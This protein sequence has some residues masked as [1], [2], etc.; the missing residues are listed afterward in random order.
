RHFTS[1]PRNLLVFLIAPSIPF[2][3]LLAWYGL[4]WNEQRPVASLVVLFAVTALNYYHLTR[5]AFGVLQLFKGKGMKPM[6]SRILTVE[7]HVVM[8]PRVLKGPADP[9]DTMLGFFRRVPVAL[10]AVLLAVAA[11]W[12]LMFHAQHAHMAGGPRFLV[13]LFDGVFVFHF[14]VEMSIWKF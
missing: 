2:L 3:G 4:A 8:A 11:G 5:Q 12:W 7:Y 10:Y 6:P 13:H 9:G 14:I 1:S